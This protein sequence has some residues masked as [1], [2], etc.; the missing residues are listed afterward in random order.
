MFA[1]S[2]DEQASSFSTFRR[3][4]KPIFKTH[5][6]C[7]DRGE[8]GQCDICHRLRLKI[9]KAGSRDE[10]RGFVHT[11]TRHLLSQWLDRAAYWQLRAQSRQYFA[12]SLRF[13]GLLQR[14]KLASSVLCI[15]QDGMDQAKLRL[16]RRGYRQS[17]KAWSKIFRP[18]CHLVGT[19]IHGFRLN[20]NL[21]D[22]D[23]KKN[24]ETS[25]ELVARALSEVVEMF[26][27]LPYHIHLQQDNCY[28]EGKNTYML[29]FILLLK[30][31]GVC[32]Y[33]S[34]GFCRVGHSHE[35]IDQCFGQIS[36]LLMGK[37]MDTPEEVLA[38]LAE[39]TGSGNPTDTTGRRIRGS[40]AA[41]SKLDEVCCWKKFVQQTG[42]RFKG[43]RRVHHFR[44]ASRKD[45][46]PVLDHIRELEDFGRSL[47]PHEDDIFLLT[48]RY[49]GDTEVQRAIAI[50]PA[51]RA[52][53]IRAGF[54]PPS[55][56]AA[57]RAIGEQLKRNI[58][59]Y[60]PPVRK[61][62][63]LSQAGADY[64]LQWSSGQLKPIRRPLHYPVFD[65]RHSAELRA[66]RHVPG[67]WQPPHRSVSLP[68]RSKSSWW[69]SYTRTSS[70]TFGKGFG[71]QC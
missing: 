50:M 7:R 29:N 12:E 43:I 46:G 5:I 16:P 24:S 68:L 11:Y 28:R 10:R 26:G 44:F 22:E 64:L 49:M 38:I 39:A 57:R 42:V 14:S 19:F 8:H 66:A 71:R 67:Q 47:V 18:A 23:Q 30:V 31:L 1:E 2:R 61:S 4:T 21:S 60:V 63:E 41:V 54:Q 3:V 6:R 34:L 9:K 58:R 37:S 17:S 13:A 55:G 33:A 69:S 27:S 51:A 65:Y 56:V 70:Q 53:E 32:G 45:L 52:A 36:R 62:G 48:K 59:K 40:Q 25:I 35:D 15:I 20:L